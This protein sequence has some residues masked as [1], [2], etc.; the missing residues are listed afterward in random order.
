MTV[1][2]SA[3]AF[4]VAIA[5]VS[6]LRSW[7]HQA[8]RRL[9]QRSLRA[10][11]ILENNAQDSAKISAD[12][13]R[14][15]AHLFDEEGKMIEPRWSSRREGLERI[16]SG[17]KDSRQ[18]L[19]RATLEWS[20][21]LEEA[22]ASAWLEVASQ[23]LKVSEEVEILQT[24]VLAL[25]SMASVWCHLETVAEPQKRRQSIQSEKEY[26]DGVLVD[27]QSALQRFRDTLAPHLGL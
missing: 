3:S 27:I 6:G 17:L 14:T 13:A 26:F 19:L 15:L 1:L 16:A 5:A 18:D 10:G 23:G 22:R 24:R 25:Q 2:P 20:I 9:A 7:K 4:V 12:S 21:A 11:L 8:S